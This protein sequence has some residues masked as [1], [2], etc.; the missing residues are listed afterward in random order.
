MLAYGLFEVPWGR[1]GDRFGA[2][3]LLVLV[4]LGGSLMTAG[5][6]AVVRLPP[7]DSVQLGWLL[8]LRFL[9][10]MFQAGTFPILA[11]LLADWMPTTERGLAQGFLWMSSRTG[12][13]LAPLVM[14]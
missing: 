10:G 2:R 8:V 13:V 3:N 1:L 6:A 14:V 11:R 12:G 7:V 9:F 5:V 4:V